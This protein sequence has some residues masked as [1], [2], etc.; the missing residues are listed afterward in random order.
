MLRGRP[1]GSSLARAQAAFLMVTRKY[2]R[3]TAR[4]RDLLRLRVPGSIVTGPSWQRTFEA[5]VMLDSPSGSREMHDS[6]Q[7]SFLF[8]PAWNASPWSGATRS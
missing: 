3:K 7:H 6:A 1:Y 2:L 8:G 5:T 4:W